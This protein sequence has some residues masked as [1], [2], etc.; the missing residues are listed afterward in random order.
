[1]LP[2]PIAFILSTQALWQP[3][4]HKQIPIWPSSPP[5][6]VAAPGPEF[7][8]PARNLVGGKPWNAV[9]NVTIPT[10]TVFQPKGMNTGVS[11][12]VFPGGGYFELAIDLEGTEICEW[13]ASRGITG[14]LLKYRV[15]YSGPHY[16]SKLHHAVVPPVLTALEDA[17]RTVGL[18]RYNAAR[19]HINPH[20]IGVI[21]FSAGGHLV[22]AISNDFQRHYA[23]VD[24]A[25]RVSCRPDF[26]IA[27]YPGHLWID[28]SGFSLNPTIKPT[29]QSA[30]TFLLQA[31]DD[32]VDGINQALVYYIALK[33]AH[34]PTEMHLYAH[35]GHAFGLRPTREPITHWPELVETW[36]RTIGVI[37]L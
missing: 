7:T 33:N 35:G 12:V 22:A 15:P 18:L 26:A 16:D 32:Y 25:D 34:V 4:G 30:P 29:S 36:L 13:L 20:K 3:V 6:S 37:R 31:E 17:Q 2:L 24:V 23:P 19:Y 1:M 8:Y 21:G 27:V 28:E 10:M 14:I 9:D 11:V 5:D